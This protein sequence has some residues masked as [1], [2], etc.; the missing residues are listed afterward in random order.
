MRPAA[1]RTEKRD[2]RPARACEIRRHDSLLGTPPLEFRSTVDRDTGPC[3]P[4][5]R[6]RSQERNHLGNVL[7]LSDSLQRLH[8]KGHQGRPIARRRSSEPL[9]PAMLRHPSWPGPPGSPPPVRLLHGCCRP[10]ISPLARSGHNGRGHAPRP[11]QAPLLSRDQFPVMRP[12][13]AQFVAKRRH[14]HPRHGG[15]LLRLHQPE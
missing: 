2:R 8:C 12:S 4:A 7:R 9:V 1:R 13:P 5:R 11:P 3:N 6:V 10:E 15:K 14:V